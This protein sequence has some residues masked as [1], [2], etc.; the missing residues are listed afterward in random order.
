MDNSEEKKLEAL[1]AFE[2]SRK[3]LALAQKNEKS[4][5][6][7]NALLCYT[8]RVSAYAINYNFLEDQILLRST[9]NG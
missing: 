1:G 3:M 7:L 4:N 5:I 2:I 6:F 9:E 8:I